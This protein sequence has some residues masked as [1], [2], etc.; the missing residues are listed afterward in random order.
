MKVVTTCVGISAPKELQVLHV[1]SIGA[2]PRDRERDT[3]GTQGCYDG[4]IILLA[5]RHH[6][7]DASRGTLVQHTAP[8]GTEVHCATVRGAR[9]C[10]SQSGLVHSSIA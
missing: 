5:C 3:G 1:P 2:V 6:V 7:V 4:L 10:G 8:V 9:A